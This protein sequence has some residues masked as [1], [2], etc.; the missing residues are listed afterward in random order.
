MQMLKKYDL[1]SAALRGVID[2]RTYY[3]RTRFFEKKAEIYF[4]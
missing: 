1:L 3:T 2:V 4:I